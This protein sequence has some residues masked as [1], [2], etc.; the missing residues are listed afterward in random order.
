MT[1]YL[2]LLVAVFT[3]FAAGAAS[4]QDRLIYFLSPESAALFETASEKASFWKLSAAFVSEDR[5]TFCGVASSVM[6][7]NALDVPPPVAPRWYPYKYWNQDN[8]FTLGA[9]EA[10]TSVAAV[11]AHGMTLPV[12]ARFIAASGAKSEPKHASDT[13]LAAF[14]ETARRVLN[15]PNAI[16]LVDIERAALGQG[17][18]PGG[19]HI[20][21]IA[22][23]NAA[24]DRFLL[25]DVARYRFKPSWIPADLL[26]AAMNTIDPD[27]NRS[28]G[29]VVVRK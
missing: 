28:R 2:R 10:A 6:A 25:L 29:Y 16:L 17:G 22:A 12:L 13:D 7:L 24:A 27:S 21:P 23:Y 5:Q 11:E 20:S 4:A 26:F 18:G 14:R 9:L 15:D 1:L 3:F 8:I 19:G